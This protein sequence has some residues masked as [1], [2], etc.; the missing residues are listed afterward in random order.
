[1]AKKL[2]EKQITNIFKLHKE[3]KSERNIAVAVVCSRSAVWGQLN[4][5]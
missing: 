4:R 1:M 2:T 5:K 3:G